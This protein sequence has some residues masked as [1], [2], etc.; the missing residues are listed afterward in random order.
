M[1]A[2]TS[3]K[4]VRPSHHAVEALLV[5]APAGAARPQVLVREA[6]LRGEQLV[7]EVAP[8][9]LADE[10]L[11]TLPRE[12]PRDDFAGRDAAEVEIG[13]EPRGRVG[14]EIVGEL[15]VAEESVVE[16]A[17]EPPAACCLAAGRKHGR[18]RAA[19]QLGPR[20]QLEPVGKRDPLRSRQHLAARLLAPAPP[21][22]REDAVVV[23]ARGRE[24]AGRDHG[25]TGEDLQLD[26]SARKRCTQP[27]LTLLRICAHVLAEEDRLG[28]GV[29][30]DPDGLREDVATPDDEGASTLAQ[31]PCRGRRGSRAGTRAGS[32]RRTMRGCRRRARTTGRCVRTARRRQRAR[33]GR[34]DGDHG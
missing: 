28:A 24:V 16:P 19:L 3:G 22:G 31:S 1:P 10:R 9:E 15:R 7:V 34:A 23:A 29:L 33:G 8:A 11:R 17:L 18:R 30:G 14:G 32:E 27:P 4:P 12:R 2:S 13:R 6:G 20:S 26:P 5:V 25:H 21:V